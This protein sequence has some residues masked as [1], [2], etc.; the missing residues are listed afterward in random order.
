MGG[1]DKND[2]NAE[3]DLGVH[4]K[5]EKEEVRR[6]EKMEMREWEK[7]FKNIMEGVDYRV[8]K[9]RRVE[10]KEMVDDK[11][12]KEKPHILL[13]RAEEVAAPDDSGTGATLLLST[14]GRP[15][16]AKHQLYVIL[17][18]V[19]SI[20]LKSSQSLST[21]RHTIKKHL[22]A[23][24]SLGRQRE[25]YDDLLINCVV[26]S[27]DPRTK[28]DWELLLAAKV[29]YP[30][31]EELDNFLVAR[32]RVLESLRGPTES[33]TSITQA[34]SK[35]KIKANAVRSHHTSMTGQTCLMCNEK[36]SFF[37]CMK[38]KTSD[39]ADKYEVAKKHQLCLNCLK[40][41]HKVIDCKSQIN[42]FKCHKRH[43][44]W[45]HR[46]QSTSEKANEEAHSENVR[47]ATASTS[48]MQMSMPS[49]AISHFLIAE[50]VKLS[51]ILLAT[52]RVWV[53]SP[54]NRAVRVRALLDQGSTW[55]F[56]SRDLAKLLGIRITPIAT[57]LT[58]VVD[59]KI[60]TVSSVAKISIATTAQG[61]KA[62]ETVALVLPK[63]T[64]YTPDCKVP[65]QT[66]PHL[67][68][69]KLAD[70]PSNEDPINM[71]IGANFCGDKLVDGLIKGHRG[72][73]FAQNT[74]FGWM[75]CD[76]GRSELNRKTII[77]SHH[78]V[79]NHELN[80]SLKQ[81]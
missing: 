30:R 24:K 68:N 13:R 57:S 39:I 74:V 28:R 25:G 23:L 9:R 70:D 7:C 36:H 32:I 66:W 11:L 34:S 78:C 59:T 53:I 56:I 33:I 16:T 1:K 65:R 26:A 5:R 52:A 31:Y 38:F 58:G 47:N 51:Q 20:K 14:R 43:H 12:S 3:A 10:K 67:A 42:C 79:S 15:W 44:T 76:L 22:E 49:Q 61:D 64:A 48:G 17:F 77:A 18:A 73:P 27:L 6:R 81:F 69:L 54:K 8:V 72:E 19:E 62:F 41:N 2:K 40:P 71:L 60:E 29:N 45:L 35:S 80:E 75:V 50:A 37:K 21:L 4:R 46:E 55:T 63:I